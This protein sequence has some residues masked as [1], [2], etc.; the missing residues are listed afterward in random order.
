M[1]WTMIA[2]TAALGLYMA[3]TVGAND[4]ANSMADAVGS[5]SISI[6]WAIVFAAICEFAGA[7]LVGSHVTDT[8]R[9]GIVSPEAITSIPGITATEAGAILAL[10]MACALLG[11]ALWLHVATWMGMPVSTTHSIVGAVTG[12]GIAAAGWSAVS[13]G[14]LGQIVASWIIS[15]VA[16]CL[17]AFLIFVAVSRSVLRNERPAKAAP[18]VMPL[19]V[20]FIVLVTMLATL[21]K[22][23]G[24]ITAKAAWL[25]GSRG[26]LI[27]VV[28]AVGAAI[29]SRR[30]VKRRLRR[31]RRS[32]LQE[33]LEQ[34]ERVFAPLVVLTSCTIAFAHGANDV[35]NAVGPL[36]AVADIVRTGTVKAQ[37]QVPL[38]VLALGG[39]GIVIGLATFGY[40][41]MHTVGTRITQL[42][43]SRGVA[44]DVAACAT[45]L[46]C[47]RL[48]LPVSTTHTL[49][50]AII[51]VG[52]ARGLGAVNR[53]VLKNIFGSWLI[54]VPAAAALTMVLFI[55]G[56][57]LLLDAIVGIMESALA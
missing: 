16:G 40:R 41:V 44:A 28:L 23:L 6:K 10:G 3:W 42:T 37:V 19:V 7:V 31:Y 49:V 38:W 20:F 2:A 48:K 46:L 12:F 17:L 56:R 55:L 43:P 32:P 45:V 27:A 35:A 25:S 13:W 4:A 14:K 29:L 50:G 53:R 18:R 57:I 22:G 26:F 21:Y 36:A 47:T 1:L 11:G 15:P 24:H 51:G 34:V 54:T 52:I 39:C 8:V 30:L 33:Q 9:K 5:R